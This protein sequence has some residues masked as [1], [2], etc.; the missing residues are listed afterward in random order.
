MSK[1]ENLTINSISAKIGAFIR[2]R[3]VQLGF[4]QKELATK[5]GITAQQVQK[6]ETGANSLRITRL[7][8]IGSALDCPLENVLLI[9]SKAHKK[10]D[11]NSLNEDSSVFQGVDTNKI[12]STL[13]IQIDRFD[14]FLAQFLSLS[15]E[16]KGHIMGVVS[17]MASNKGANVSDSRK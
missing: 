2:Q 5:L 16:D 9:F 7:M 13:D 17:V 3:R 14:T 12:P 10:C 8:Q 6:Y 11:Q 4:T 1:E 15:D